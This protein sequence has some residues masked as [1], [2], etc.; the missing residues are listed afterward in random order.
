[1]LESNMIPYKGLDD[2]EEGLYYLRISDYT[3][4]SIPYL[5]ILGYLETI[6]VK[7]YPHR[8]ISA[9]IKV[10]QWR[11]NNGHIVDRESINIEHYIFIEPKK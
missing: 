6:E 7:K 4:E 10:K 8:K 5:D 11:I 1:M 2:L 9:K 3:F